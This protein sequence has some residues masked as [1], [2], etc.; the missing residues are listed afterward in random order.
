MGDTDET[1]RAFYAPSSDGSLIAS[2]WTRGPWDNAMQHGGPPSAL[3]ARAVDRELG[4]EHTEWIP[5][6]T[7]VE[8]LRPVPIATLR[9]RASIE[10]RGRKALRAMASLEH[11]GVD[12]ARAR[13]TMVR[14]TPEAPETA[15]GALDAGA[16]FPRPDDLD[17]FEF[18]F[19]LHPVGY[20]RAMELRISEGWPAA[21]AQAWARM[22]VPLVEGEEPSGWERALC[23]ADAAHGCAPGLDPR[24]HILVNPDLELS[25]LR[26]PIGEWI[27]LDIRTV[28]SGIGTGITRSRVVDERGEVGGTSAALVVRPRPGG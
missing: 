9:T 23:F 22:R 15:V 6:R 26:R 24:R 3:L 10:S 2:A 28:T 1:L 11:E 27:G 20:H 14:S 12:I 4:G 5:V 19:F 8:L 16:S 18:S 25:L 17:P 21:G 7:V 13:V